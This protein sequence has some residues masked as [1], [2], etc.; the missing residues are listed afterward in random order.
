MKNKKYHFIT[1]KGERIESNN[2][3]EL[4]II[5]HREPCNWVKIYM[6]E[7]YIIGTMG[8]KQY[9]KYLHRMMVREEMM[10]EI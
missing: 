3:G 10:K 7:S 9:N 2:L 5:A 1:S 6:Y 8:A 4:K